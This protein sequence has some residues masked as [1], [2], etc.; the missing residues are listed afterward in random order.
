M[1]LDLRLALLRLADLNKEIAD[2][3]VSEIPPYAAT[4]E[5]WTDAGTFVTDD[6]FALSDSPA[7][8]RGELGVLTRH[9]RPL[10]WLFFALRRLLSATPAPLGEEALFGRL[11]DAANGFLAAH[12]PEGGD[13][14][15]LLCVVVREAHRAFADAFAVTEPKPRAF[16]LRPRIHPAPAFAVAA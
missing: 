9:A 5:L 7:A 12:Q 3:T 2:A 8:H 10:S 15:P 1:N 14:R 11:A 16:A 4:A 13:W 6:A